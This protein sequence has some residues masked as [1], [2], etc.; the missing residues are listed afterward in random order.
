MKQY[1]PSGKIES[2]LEVKINNPIYSANGRY[3]AIGEKDSNKIYLICE[4]NI[5]W[6]KEIEGNISK[7]NVNPN[8][9]VSIVLKGTT[10][11]TVIATY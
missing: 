1:S 4:N 3:L 11:K 5:L 10:D 8:G 2:E 7:I 6:E 9:Y